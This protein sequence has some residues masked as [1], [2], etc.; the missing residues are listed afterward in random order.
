MS[1]KNENT[2]FQCENCST[3]V[4]P[5]S[6]GSFRNHCPNCLFSKHMD[7]V[8]GDRA[9]T[10][11]GLMRP[12]AVDYTGKKGFQLI[13]QCTKCQKKGRNKVAVDSIQEDQI[14]QF[15]ESII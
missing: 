12:I 15:M 10:C 1:R 11:K 5:L 3:M 14:I 9:S 4:E 7:N 13:H 6:N 8:P 2:A